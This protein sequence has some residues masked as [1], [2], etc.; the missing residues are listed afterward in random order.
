MDTFQSIL[1]G[2][3]KAF[4][5]F[6]PLSSEAHL[7]AFSTLLQWPIPG[8]VL[9]GTLHLACATSLLIYFRHDWA[10]Q[11]SGALTPLVD[12]RMPQMLDERLPFLVML[13]WLLPLGVATQGVPRLEE[14][15]AFD[16]LEWSPY[17][18]AIFLAVGAAMLWFSEGFSR[19]TK[20]LPDW[21][22]LDTLLLGLGLSLF[23]VPGIGAL[24][25][26]LT[27]AYLRNY[28]REGALRFA[29]FCLFPLLI[30]RGLH[31]LNE[32]GVKLM[33]FSSLTD[34]AVNE[35]LST[36]TLVTTFV[37]AAVSGILVLHSF[38]KASNIGLMN[39]P[40]PKHL[41]K[42]ISSRL[43]LAVGLALVVWVRSR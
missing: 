18:T 1:L 38:T 34:A 7:E 29:Y 6:L 17:L 28:N 13:A 39:D 36:M 5:E 26:A 24:T 37:V 25:G 4:S 41:G 22:V 12:R 32:A 2:I 14:M 19:K 20:S 31:T 35:G 16:R 11:I 30:F 27:I 15:G 21:T 10:G 43:A 8:P 9:K 23:L 40:G 33:P 42:I 3:L